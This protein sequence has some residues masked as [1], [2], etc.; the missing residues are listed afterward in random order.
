M[1]SPKPPVSHPPCRITARHARH[2]H[3]AVC[4]LQA[5]LKLRGT[6]G[7]ITIG[8][9]FQSMDDDNDRK[10][11][12]AE[13]TKACREMKLALSEADM[14]RLFRCARVRPWRAAVGER[15]RRGRACLGI[16]VRLSAPSR[17]HGM[18]RLYGCGECNV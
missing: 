5:A 15:R 18:A 17:A 14:T 9:K 1:N 13:F 7:I 11:S 10:I 6:H 3:D 16:C 4:V 12:Y 2:D 8:K